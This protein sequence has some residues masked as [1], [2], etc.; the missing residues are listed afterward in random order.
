MHPLR[1]TG[2]PPLHFFSKGETKD[3][4]VGALMYASPDKMQASTSESATLPKLSTA[5]A[6]F[7][8]YSFEASQTAR[9]P[10]VAPP[11]CSIDLSYGGH[12]GRK[13]QQHWMDPQTQRHAR[14]Q[15]R[16]LECRLSQEK[17][18]KAQAKIRLLTDRLT[19]AERELAVEIRETDKINGELVALRKKA[20]HL[21]P[22]LQPN[23]L[24]FLH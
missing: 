22:T 18:G 23:V 5:R 1:V 24:H 17:V 11:P 21:F 7:P 16:K 14:R 2:I 6:S 12:N 15:K 19:D 9:T 13:Q 10:R 4:V 3:D 20:S 8:R